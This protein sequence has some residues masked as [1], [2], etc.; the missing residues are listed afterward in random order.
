MDDYITRTEHNEFAARIDAENNR[1]NHRIKV[2][3]DEMR[4]IQA[5][6]I[7]IERMASSIEQIAKETAKQGERL[8][9][10]EQLPS[11]KWDKLISGIIGAIATAIGGGLIWAII[12]NIH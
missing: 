10:L 6:N 7:S 1:Q 9:R 8:E 11:Q 3:E 5:L 4:Q 12:S 2:V